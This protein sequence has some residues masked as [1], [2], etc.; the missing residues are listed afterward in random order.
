VAAVVLKAYLAANAIPA[1]RITAFQQALITGAKLQR[2]ISRRGNSKSV[3]TPSLQG[4]KRQIVI[5]DQVSGFS[6]TNNCSQIVIHYTKTG[7]SF[8]LLI[9]QIIVFKY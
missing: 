8:N 7:V 5:L 1:E 6:G 3:L 4:W 2:T 9:C